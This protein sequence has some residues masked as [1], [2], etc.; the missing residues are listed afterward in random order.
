[1]DLQKLRSPGHTRAKIELLT[2]CKEIRVREPGASGFC[3]WLVIF[4]LNLPDRQV[5]FFGEIQIT[6]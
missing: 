6:D 1:M 4:V 2:M 3:Y 5:L